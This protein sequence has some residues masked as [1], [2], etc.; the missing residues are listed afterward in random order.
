M[1]ALLVLFRLFAIACLFFQFKSFINYIMQLK[2]A[3]ST[4]R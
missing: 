3:T 4:S 2:T 1:Q